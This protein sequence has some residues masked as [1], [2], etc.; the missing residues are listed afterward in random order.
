MVYVLINVLVV[1]DTVHYDNIVT[2]YICNFFLI[3][4]IVDF[5]LVPFEYLVEIGCNFGFFAI[6]INSIDN[7][8]M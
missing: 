7:K 2:L 6:L 5:I 8:F 3:L 4:C 1:L